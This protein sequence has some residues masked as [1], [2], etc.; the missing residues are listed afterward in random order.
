M[1][2]KECSSCKKTLE[3]SLFPQGLSK[4]RE[5]KRKYQNEWYATTKINTAP[6]KRI[7]RQSARKR[8]QD[9]VMSNL[10]GKSC[11][12]CGNSNPIVL[13][14]DHVKGEKFGAVAKMVHDGYSVKRIEEEIQKCVI[15]CANCHAIK[16]YTQMGYKSKH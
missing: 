11:V 13:Q 12:D 4:C 5:C 16:T 1:E 2:T 3:I 10:K 7:N 8:A 15:R 9:C 14:F 6:Q